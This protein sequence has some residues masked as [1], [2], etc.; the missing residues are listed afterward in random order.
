MLIKE[1]QAVFLE[2]IKSRQ[3]NIYSGQVI[4]EL[5]ANEPN[6]AIFRAKARLY[7]KHYERDVM[8]STQINLDVDPRSPRAL[9]LSL[10]ELE[11][12]PENYSMLTEEGTPVQ[13]EDE[14][15]IRL[16]SFFS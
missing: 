2:A 1:W 12:D 10:E 3:H 14:G 16:E 8:T 13:T 11:E 7:L 6:L 5:L 4:K 9:W 15:T